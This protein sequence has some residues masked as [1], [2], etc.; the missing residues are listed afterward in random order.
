MNYTFF[1]NVVLFLI[2][3][4]ATVALF[5]L[6]AM[7]LDNLNTPG[8]CSLNLSFSGLQKEQVHSGNSIQLFME[9]DEYR[10]GLKSA[11]IGTPIGECF[12]FCEE[13]VHACTDPLLTAKSCYESCVICREHIQNAGPS[14]C[15]TSRCA[16]FN[17]K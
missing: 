2:G 17:F 3:S 13:S 6:S 15:I 5:V 10:L 1:L 12:D 4:S 11:F 9:L 7:I 14:N 8:E 16:N